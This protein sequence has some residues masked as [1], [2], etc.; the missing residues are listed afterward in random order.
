MR[1]WRYIAIGAFVAL[2]SVV[3]L[4]VDDDPQPDELRTIVIRNDCN[5]P[6]WVFYGRAPPVRPQDSASIGEKS[7]S[8]QEMLE[9]DQVWLLE[10]D[11]RS[12]LG[13]A[14]VGPSTKRIVIEAS[15]QSIEEEPFTPR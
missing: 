14:T 5:H 6:V 7:S 12:P 8:A 15:C 9:G 2:I 3:L 13:Q 11:R 1:L 10:E 4:G